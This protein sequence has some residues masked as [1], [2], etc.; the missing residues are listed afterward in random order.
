MTGKQNLSWTK[1]RDRSQESGVRSQKTAGGLP[2]IEAN[3]PTRYLLF[4][5]RVTRPGVGTLL[6]NLISYRFLK[7]SAG[8]SLLPAAYSQAIA[9]SVF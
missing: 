5:G 7:M 8:Q 1:S 6:N 2:S 4:V 3:P 9:S